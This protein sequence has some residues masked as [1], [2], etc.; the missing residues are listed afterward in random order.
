MKILIIGYDHEEGFARYVADELELLGHACVRY[1][2]GPKLRAFQTPFGYYANRLKTLGHLS[3]QQFMRATG[4]GTGIAAI[5]RVLERS[6]RVDLTLVLHDFLSPDDAMRVRTLTG[7][8]LA[9]W[10]PDP[11]WE[12]RTPYVLERTL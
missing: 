8:P 2:P 7:G 4:L 10:Y 9:L 3:V 11:I 1:D 12:F 5:R 6:G